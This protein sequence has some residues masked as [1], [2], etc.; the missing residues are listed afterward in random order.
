MADFI[1]LSYL[2]NDRNRVCQGYDKVPIM[3]M[4]RHLI[5][6]IPTVSKFYSFVFAYSLR[7][8][9]V[10]LAVNL[11]GVDLTQTARCNV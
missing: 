10:E 4:H 6:P 2:E 7:S 11:V 1:P 3:D 9:S 5:N 8:R